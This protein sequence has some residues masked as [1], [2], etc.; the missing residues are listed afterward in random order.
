MLILAC[1]RESLYDEQADVVKD[2]LFSST[3]QN[4][5]I[6]DEM[7]SDEESDILHNDNVDNGGEGER[8]QHPSHSHNDLLHD[9]DDCIGGEGQ[10]ISLLEETVKTLRKEIIKMQE[11][12]E[13]NNEGTNNL[14]SRLTSKVTSLYELRLDEGENSP[15]LEVVE[16]IQNQNSALKSE[17]EFLR[18]RIEVMTYTLSDLNNKIKAAEQE[19]ESLLTAIRLIYE[20]AKA[21]LPDG[22]ADQQTNKVGDCEGA[23]VSIPKKRKQPSARK[24]VSTTAVESPFGINQYSL[25]SVEEVPNNNEEVDD[26]TEVI[27]V[28]KPTTRSDGSRTRHTQTQKEQHQS[29]DKGGSK[30]KAWFT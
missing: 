1:L 21:K 12:F 26:I 3:Q 30:S 29:R 4:Q 9:Y 27:H 25:L 17:N 18:E 8:S 6:L 24:R 2:K 13:I 19:K 11:D 15:R 28:I 10:H 20:D 22:D 7:T 5:E 14:L 23:Y 16:V